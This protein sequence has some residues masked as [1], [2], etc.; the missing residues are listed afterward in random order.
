MKE[1]DYITNTTIIIISYRSY[2]KIQNFLKNKPKK[3]N[4]I[5]I[6]NSDDDKINKLKNKN[7]KI[8]KQPN[9]GISS[10][11]N[12]ACKKV[13][14]K[15]FF[16]FSPDIIIKNDDIKKIYNHAKGLKDN[17]GAIGPRFMNVNSK[18]HKQSNMNFKLSKIS[19]IHGSAMFIKLKNYYKIGKFDENL[20][21]F[22]EENDFCKRANKHKLFCYQVNNVKI[23]NS[24]NGSINYKNNKEKKN[25]EN[26]YTWHFIWSKFYFTKKHYGF[27]ISILY[28]LPIISRII[29]RVSIYS[30]ISS[31]KKD[32]YVIR[33]NGLISSILG[34]KSYLRPKDIIL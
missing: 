33:L 31:E 17:F 8:F 20:F 25:I 22:F 3:L 2:K 13:K 18:S 15:Y 12:Y 34:K 19:A 6:E 11:I 1:K 29:F 14:T 30:L 5:I 9:K 26:I 27:L 4:I 24:K 7:I 23:K 32:K 16:H 10:S 28:F 21:L